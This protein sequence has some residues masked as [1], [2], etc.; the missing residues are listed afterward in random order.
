MKIGLIIYGALD[1]LSGGYL[2]DRQLVAALR[3][4]G[5]QVDILSLPWR[6]YASHLCDNFRRG[7]ARAIGQA[8]Y[9]LLLQDELNHPSLAWLNPTLRTTYRGP[10]ISI[11]HHLRSQEQHPAWLLPLYRQ[12]ESRY[13]RS[14]DGFL[15]NSRTTRAIVEG[16]VGAGVPGHVAYPAADHIRPPTTAEIAALITR[17]GAAERPLHLLFVGNVIPR[18]GLHTVLA[19]LAPLP[20]TGWHLHIVGSLQSDIAYTKDMQARAHALGL[21]AGI[22]WHGRLT[23]A[24]LHRQ[25][26]IADCFILPSYEGFGIAY[27]EAMA[28]GLPVVAL[29]TGAAY[30]LV[31]H[32]ENGFLIQ[33]EG[34]AA[35]TDHLRH[36]ISH[37][38]ALTRMAHAARTTYDRHPTW[39]QSMA[40]ASQWLH[41]FT[42]RYTTP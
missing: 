29:T 42:H 25:Y 13:L 14:V 15:Y 19:A 6:N 31:T 39:A 38:A 22:T 3:A 36:L 33:P 17:R 21:D 9:D 16:L 24:D 2:Y 18:K 10:M 23:D 32:G 12:V 35:L 1:T 4:E 7:W 40:G 41:E 5:H 28:F 37:R 11:V 26:Q 20:H 27:L 30:E 8:G 34:H